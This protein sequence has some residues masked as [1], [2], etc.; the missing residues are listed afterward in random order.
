VVSPPGQLRPSSIASPLAPVRAWLEHARS[1]LRIRR[2]FR[3][4]GV[5]YKELSAEP[6]TEALAAKGAGRKDYRATFADGS[7]M[8]LRCSHSRCYPDLMGP[9][10]I[11]RYIRVASILRPGSRVLEV[12]AD[13]MTTG[14]G[15]AWL[16]RMVGP[17]GAVV[18][19]IEDEEGAKFAPRR[20]ALDNLSFERGPLS[21]ALAGET[22]GSFDAVIC[23][24]LPAD[25]AARSARLREV[26]RVLAPGG[27]LLA[28]FR[29]WD[30]GVESATMLETDLGSLGRIV[31]PAEASET[32]A[33]VLAR[34]AG[35][36]ADQGRAPA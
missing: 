13:P 2:G 23:L 12:A 9:R 22:D 28:G 36:E 18:S 19:V 25:P 26:W 34:K 11:E 20:Y 24:G 35:S 31:E 1:A 10:G 7:K 27:W 33:D 3:G 8:F 29:P 4:E 6:L 21:D 17:S 14:Y 15:G 30:Q 5:Y 16:A 32:P